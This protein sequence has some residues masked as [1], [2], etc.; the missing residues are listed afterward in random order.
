MGSGAPPRDIQVS[1]VG[2]SPDGR[3][4]LVFLRRQVAASCDVGEY[5]LVA[6][7]RATWQ[8]IAYA[9]RWIS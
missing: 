6:R 9:L 7:E 8:V 1:Q 4:A 5:Y 3:L 2:Y